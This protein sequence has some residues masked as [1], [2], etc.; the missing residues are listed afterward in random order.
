MG[1]DGWPAVGGRGRQG[2]VR[3]CKGRARRQRGGAFLRG[4]EGAR[5]GP[6]AQAGL[7]EALGLAV[8]PRRVRPGTE[9]AQR[10]AAT[11]VAPVMAAVR[12]AVVGHDALDRHT[13]ASEPGDRALQERHRA[14]LAL[15]RQ[16]L[17]VGQ[18]GGVVDA[19]MNGLPAGAPPGIAPIA[20]RV[21][22]AGPRT[23]LARR[24]VARAKSR[25]WR[26]LTTATASPAA[27]RSA[28]ARSCR[29]PVASRTTRH[30]PPPTARRR[31]SSLKPWS[32]WT[33]AK[34]SP[35]GRR[36]TSSRALLTSM[37]MKQ[38]TSSMR[39]TLP[40]EFGL[41]LR[42]RRLSGRGPAPDGPHDSPTASAAKG[43]GGVPPGL[44]RAVP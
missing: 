26:G 23:S 4:R 11:G 19:D 2:A 13:L 41:A 6:L 3:Y 36:Y 20:P 18:A 25:T 29:P 44:V 28:A 33:T 31:V 32:S 40:C 30:D 1:A 14:G 24:P 27:L 5:I 16:R 21:R 7:D 10:E 37:P 15:V 9:M 12:R 22:L 43:R 34:L 35:C 39:H 17:A 38:L 42:P 8:G